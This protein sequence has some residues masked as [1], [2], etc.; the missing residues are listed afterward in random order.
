MYLVACLS[1]FAAAYLLNILTIT[2]GYHRAL[3]HKAVT[4]SPGLRRLVVAGGSWITGLDAKSWVVMHRMHHDSHA[5]ASLLF[6]ASP[7][8]L[9]LVR[10]APCGT[11][12][13]GRSFRA[14]NASRTM[15]PVA[16]AAMRSMGS[17]HW[18][19]KG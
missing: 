3:A 12:R 19:L 15:T 18:F 13:A 4:L 5:M 17:A 1:V 9:G 16:F 14:P 2:I 6:G 10:T 8:V 11:R 7:R